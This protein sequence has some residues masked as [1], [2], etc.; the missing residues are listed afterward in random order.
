MVTASTAF[1]IVL[2]DGAQYECSGATTVGNTADT[3][4]SV[5]CDIFEAATTT[6]ILAG[7]VGFV[8]DGAVTNNT[9]TPAAPGTGTEINVEGSEII[10]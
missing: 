2:A 4:A 6:Q 10:S 3:G 8:D 9:G 7:V 5:S 1:G